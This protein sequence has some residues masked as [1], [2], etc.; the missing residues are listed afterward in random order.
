MSRG[1][2]TRYY[3]MESRFEKCA[4]GEDFKAWKQARKHFLQKLGTD[5]SQNKLAKVEDHRLH[6]DAH[7]VENKKRCC[8]ELQGSKSHKSL[9][10]D[11]VR[12]V[13]T[14]ECRMDVRKQR[15]L[16]RMEAK[17]RRR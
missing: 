11:D 1:S 5:E 8:K 3:E 17:N 14:K 16:E 7:K 13:T 10:S 9:I 4:Y 6:R 2:T 15:C 12:Q